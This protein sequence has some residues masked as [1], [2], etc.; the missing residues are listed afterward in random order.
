[1][2]ISVII[3]VHNAEKTLEKCVRSVL[4]QAW[5]A[6]EVLLV[7][8]GSADGSAETARLL[9]G[10]DERVRLLQQEHAGV[11]EAR[12]RGLKEAR[13]DAVLFLDADDLLLPGALDTLAACLDGGVDAGCGRILRGR[14]KNRKHPGDVAVIRDREKLLNL[15]LARPTDLLTVHGWLIRR[16]VILDSGIFFDAALR[17]GE[18]SDWVMRVLKAGNGAALTQDAVYRYALNPDS[19]VHSWRKGQTDGFLRMLEKTREF[20]GGEKNWPLFALTT[21]LLILTHDTLHPANPANRAEKRKEIGRLRQLPVF[22][23]A[24]E[25]ADL[26]GL[27]P[28][29]RR[30][31]V[32]LREG[33]DGLAEQAIRMRQLQ[34]R[35]CRTGEL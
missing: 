32:W 9:C 2:E 18:D 19:A 13:G 14:Q 7:D 11:S 6:V 33:K 22:R 20:A 17:L 26:S 30:V 21:L 15:A 34:N 24:F 8:D 23:E 35:C 12:N 16:S 31:L 4:A 27:E 28:K 25:K 29:R 5:R 1:M 10:R 3:P